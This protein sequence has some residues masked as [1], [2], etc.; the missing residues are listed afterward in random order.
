[1]DGGG[2]FRVG[3]ATNGAAYLHFDQDTSAL[4]IKTGVFKLDTSNLDID[5]AAG[6]SGS[7]ALGA[8]PPTQ[9]NNGTGFFVDGSGKF[10][11]GDSDNN[12]VQFDGTTLTV[13]GTINIG[14]G[15][16]AGVS[17]DTIS[18]SYPPASASQDLGF[19]TQVVLDSDGM[20]LKNG[21]A[22]KT[23]AI[24]GKTSK[25]F[26]GLNS[27]TYTEVGGKG[28]TQ[29]SGS[30]TGSLL[31]NGVMSLF[32]AGVEKAVFSSTGSLF[33]G[34]AANTFTR[35][36]SSG[37][38]IVDNGVTQG[39]FSNGTINLYGNNGTDRRVLIDSNGFKAYYD[40][41]NYAFVK[42]TGLE[43]I[44]SGNSVADFGDTMR[45]G[46]YGNHS[47]M[48]VSAS[49]MNMYVYN[50]DEGNTHKKL[51][52]G[53]NSSDELVMAIGGANDEDV[54]ATTSNNVLR[55]T[56]DDVRIFNNS[57]DFVKIHSNHPLKSYLLDA[58][59]VKLS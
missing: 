56:N 57:N 22:T 59:D 17:S 25:I 51:F 54:T 11:L 10:L 38:T 46:Q 8:T 44:N 37:L 26:D 21:D 27:N 12:K 39:T 31:T 9:Y 34:D 33:R 23:L 55:I 29:V 14:S 2:N 4:D 1:M 53:P 45:V 5:S 36:D 47:R 52:I 15:D 41:N 13:A 40:S 20:S 58:Q 6:G 19:A 32:G 49:E 28:I 43:V 16:L 30:V 18:G 35:V 42:S 50:A 7:I 48:E 3:T 24:Y